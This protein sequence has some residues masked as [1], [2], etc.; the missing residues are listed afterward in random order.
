M[1]AAAVQIG[2]TVTAQ[3]TF[4]INLRLNGG[5]DAFAEINQAERVYSGS[6]Q[7]QSNQADS[8]VFT[9]GISG[10]NAVL[11][12]E[13]SINVTYATGSSASTTLGTLTVYLIVRAGVPFNFGL[14]D[15]VNT[16]GG[17]TGNG[18]SNGTIPGLQFV[19]PPDAA[20]DPY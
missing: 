18:L 3:E 7:T 13:P 10:N 8:S 19:A 2:D 12:S 1:S 17:D 4:D 15:A 16:H 5:A 20:V 14:F 11:L 9:Y 6:S